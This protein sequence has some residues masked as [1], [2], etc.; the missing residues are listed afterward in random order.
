MP[1]VSLKRRKEQM[2]ELTDST[3]PTHEE[4]VVELYTAIL[5]QLTRI[6]D[7]LAYGP[8][9]AL[10]AHKNGQTLSYIPALGQFKDLAND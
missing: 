1:S 5:V 10:N 4:T 2:S 7:V 8:G 3:E 9:P 6:Y